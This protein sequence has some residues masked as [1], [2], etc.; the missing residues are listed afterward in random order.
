MKLIKDFL[1]LIG[2]NGKKEAKVDAIYQQSYSKVD[3]LNQSI[4]EVNKL[5]YS[6]TV[7]YY[8]LKSMGVIKPKIRV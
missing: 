1:H 4:K 5:L 8:I 7:N 3:D 2:L 6:K